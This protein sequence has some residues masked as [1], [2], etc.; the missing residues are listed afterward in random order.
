MMLPNESLYADCRTW[1]TESTILQRD[2][3]DTDD[4]QTSDHRPVRA[5]ITIEYRPVEFLADLLLSQIY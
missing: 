1:K 2:A 5:E 4:D 3:N